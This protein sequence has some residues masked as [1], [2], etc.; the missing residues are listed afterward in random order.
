MQQRELKVE[1]RSKTGKG[2]AR[3][4]RIAGKVPGIVYGKG[5]ESVCVSVSPKELSSAI[6]GEGGRN[7]LITLKGGAVDGK[8]VIVVDVLRDSLKGFPLHVDFHNVDMKEKI[9]VHV[10]VSLVGTSV[11]VKEGGLLD[12]VMHKLSVECLPGQIPEH[13]EV[14]VTSLT[15]GHSIHVGDLKLPAGVKILDDTKASVVSV[16]GRGKEEAPAEAP[17][18]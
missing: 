11:G 7:N 1:Q 8:V 14:D 5:M 9:K 18:S 12:F 13:I 16:L 6:A 15:I 17:A 3:Q 10:P 2:A 4:L